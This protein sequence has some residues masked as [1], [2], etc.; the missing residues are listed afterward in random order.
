MLVFVYADRL[1]PTSKERRVGSYRSSC[2]PVVEIYDLCPCCI[3]D[4]VKQS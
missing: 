2:C 4:V 3:C 1:L